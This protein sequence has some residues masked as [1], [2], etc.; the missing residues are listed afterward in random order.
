MASVLYRN[1][2]YEIEFFVIVFV[3][4][5]ASINKIVI[6]EAVICY[7][8]T[9]IGTDVGAVCGK[10]PAHDTSFITSSND[11]HASNRFLVFDV[12]ISELIDFP[13]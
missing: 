13:I 5:R 9:C 6:L 3:K 4:I 12:I 7:L 11:G 1:S 2:F 8:R 10:V